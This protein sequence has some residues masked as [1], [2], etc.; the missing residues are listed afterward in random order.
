M[1]PVDGVELARTLPPSDEETIMENPIF[2]QLDIPHGSSCLPTQ[3]L[4][5]T[6]WPTKEQ[7]SGSVDDFIKLLPGAEIIHQHEQTSSPLI[8]PNSTEKYPL[9]GGAKDKDPI[10]S[11]LPPDGGGT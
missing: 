3:Q 11:N 9:I 4:P 8:L 6:T 10:I 7:P 1:S 5:T 2:R